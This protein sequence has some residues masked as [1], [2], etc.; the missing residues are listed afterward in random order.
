MAACVLHFVIGWFVS[1]LDELHDELPHP[2]AGVFCS[3]K[4]PGSFPDEMRV[5]KDLS[6]QRFVLCDTLID[7]HL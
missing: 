3:P 6:R 1:R 5:P 7:C 2:P 4:P